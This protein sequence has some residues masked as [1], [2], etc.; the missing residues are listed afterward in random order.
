[1][2][3]HLFRILAPPAIYAACFGSLMGISL[4]VRAA[5]GLPVLGGPEVFL[6]AAVVVS[7]LAVATLA[8]LVPAH[9]RLK[10]FLI[11]FG[12]P[13]VFCSCALIASWIRTGESPRPNAT[14]VWGILMVA[15]A[16]GLLVHYGSKQKAG[17]PPN[18]SLER[19]RDR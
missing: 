4:L 17:S 8:E 2:N 3:H 1:M 14:S 19:T 16:A 5:L 10:R 12:A 18:T 9:V 6:L 11:G 13:V 15:L 7:V